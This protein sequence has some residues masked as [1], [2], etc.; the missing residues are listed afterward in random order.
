[1]PWYMPALGRPHVYKFSYPV[2]V[3][4]VEL[5]VTACLSQLITTLLRLLEL[6]GSPEV[7]GK[8]SYGLDDE[9]ATLSN[10]AYHEDMSPLRPYENGYSEDHV[11]ANNNRRKANIPL[12]PTAV[13]AIRQWYSSARMKSSGH[14]VQFRCLPLTVALTARLVLGNVLLAD[15]EHVAPNNSGFRSFSAPARK[16]LLAIILY[17]AI[18]QGSYTLEDY[19]AASSTSLPYLAKQDTRGRLNINNGPL[20]EL[21][22]HDNFLGSRPEMDTFADINAITAN[23]VDSDGG[24]GV[25][26]IRHCLS[27][28]ATSQEDYLISP[29]NDHVTRRRRDEN[30]GKLNPTLSNGVCSG[31]KTLYHTYWTGPATWRVELFIKA[32]LYTQNLFCSRLWIWLDGD[33]D[34]LAIDKMLHRD[35]LFQ[36]F[37]ALLDNEY[38]VLKKWT[39]PQRIPLPRA[40]HAIDTSHLY[41]PSYQN[42]NGEVA[43]AD[44]VIQDV[45]GML[46]LVPD[47]IHKAVSTPTQMSDFVRF[48]VLHLHGGVYLDMD[49][50]LLRDLRPLLLPKPAS[51]N[52]LQPA[53]AEQWVERCSP[54]DINTAVLSLPANSSLTSYVLRGGL[55]MGMNFHPRII[56]RMLWKVGRGSELA[57]LHNAVFDPLVT[58]RRRRGTNICTVPCLKNWASA[59]M[60]NVEE[61]QNEWSNYEV[62]GAGGAININAGQNGSA[63]TNRSM[64]H[65]FRGAFAYHIHNQVGSIAPALKKRQ[66]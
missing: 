49:V 66:N 8:L 29:R 59:F 34:S 42:A 7:Y 3:T 28:L 62:N 30:P 20:I 58:D 17:G 37:H 9:S 5:L 60:A 41:K 53:W 13:D 23:C 36:R 56:G 16:A 48:F 61:P 31:P 40:S 47:T 6:Q 39:F 65:F 45:S 52:A 27:Y 1:M 24:T 54:D 12:L 35:P 64:E 19:I 43:V 57:V 22:A 11:T 26:D 33:T 18:Y 46:W 4:F 15:D 38:I 21:P 51:G 44:G 32:Y 50:L 55:R 63:G 2:A 25:N 14:G 10:L